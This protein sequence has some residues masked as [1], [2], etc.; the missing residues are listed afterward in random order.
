MDANFEEETLCATGG[1]VFMPF[2]A[3]N[4]ALR[5]GKNVTQ[6]AFGDFNVTHPEFFQESGNMSFQPAISIVGKQT[7]GY[8]TVLTVFKCQVKAIKPLKRF[9]FLLFSQIPRL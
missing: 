4:C 8:S 6:G 5:R 2:L 3:Q 1:C 7:S 9:N